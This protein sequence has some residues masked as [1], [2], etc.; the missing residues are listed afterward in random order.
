MNKRRRNV[1][2]LVLDDLERLRDPMMDG[3]E[4]SL[5]LQEVQNNI[6]SCLDEEEEALDNR[7][8][9]LR[10]SFEN[11]NMSENISDLSDANDE[12]S[13][14]IDKCQEIEMFDYELVKDDVIR[15]VNIIKRTIHR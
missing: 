12:L 4:A 10:W 5:I 3:E 7:P 6:E 1:L 13:I 2:H 11:D 8:E 14:L 15:I 9:S